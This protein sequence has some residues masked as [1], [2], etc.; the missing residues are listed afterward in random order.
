[1]MA[2]PRGK[3]AP[4]NTQISISISAELLKETDEAAAEENRTRS[5]YIVD[6]L[7]KRLERR[8]AEKALNASSPKSKPSPFPSAAEP[9][10]RRVNVS[11]NEDAAAPAALES[12]ASPK[13]PKLTRISLR[14]QSHKHRPAEG[15]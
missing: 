13:I 9:P 15:S 6:L 1:M 8:R 2:M 7:I 4:G 12:A 5:N 10:P 3:R 11:L 14:E